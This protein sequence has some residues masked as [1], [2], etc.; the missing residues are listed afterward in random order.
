MTPASD[1][2]PPKALQAALRKTTETLAHELAQPT[3]SAPVWSDLEW[4]IARAVAAIHGVSALLSR[5]LRWQGPAEWNEFLAQQRTQTAARHA[6]IEELLRLIDM[7]AGVEGICIVALKGAELHAMGLYAA[8]ERPM[9]DVDLLVRAADNERTTRML[10]SL[11]FHESFSM[12]RHSVFTRG[13]RTAPC[14]LGEHADN[15]LKIELHQRIREALPLDTADISEWVFPTQPRP[16]LNPYPS[17][18]ALM[19]HLLL[20]AAGA[21]A[22][23]SLRLL[24]LHDLALL[25]SHMAE[26]DWDDL[27]QQSAID[28]GHRWALPPLHLTARYYGHAVPSRVLTALTAECPRL[29]RAIVPRRRLSDVSLSRLGIEAFPGIELSRSASEMARYIV[30]R[31]RPSG[32]RLAVREHTAR[33]QVAASASQWHQLSQSRRVLRWVISRPPRAYTMLAVRMA[34]DQAQP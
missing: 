33:T 20:H 14:S 24:H 12:W 26:R 9:A 16:G 21:M 1:L 5:A 4:R 17:R 22:D 2:P 18:A 10:E 23:R 3:S 27:L 28:H 32:E 29:L 8:G 7:H 13:E 11:G 34:L 19:S 6:R 25:S 15:Y 31:L 30:N